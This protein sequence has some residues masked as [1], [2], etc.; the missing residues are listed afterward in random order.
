[1][2][3]V[4]PALINDRLGIVYSNRKLAY[5]SMIFLGRDSYLRESMTGGLPPLNG[6]D[7]CYFVDCAAIR[8]RQP[9]AFSVK[10]V[11]DVQRLDASDISSDVD[12]FGP[13]LARHNNEWG[14]AFSYLGPFF[15]FIT[16][17]CAYFNEMP[18]SRVHELNFIGEHT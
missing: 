11:K 5:A 4:Y 18:V 16:Q 7:Q 2:E 6:A 14:L 13:V 8:D 17:D 10:S 15:D 1:M 3:G 12:E 9:D